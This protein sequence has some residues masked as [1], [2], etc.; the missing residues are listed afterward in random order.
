M[1][2]DSL[3]AEHGSGKKLY[4]SPNQSSSTGINDRISSLEVVLMQ[5]QKNIES[6]QRVSTMIS[7]QNVNLNN[8]VTDEI[9]LYMTTCKRIW[10]QCMKKS[11]S[12]T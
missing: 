12:G 11:I 5:Q 1:L 8:R 2:S 3:H 4:S 7:G 10:K 9:K 6:M